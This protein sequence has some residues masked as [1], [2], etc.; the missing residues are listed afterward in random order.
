MNIKRDIARDSLG[1][2]N[3]L[4]GKLLVKE[5]NKEIE[6]KKFY[7]MHALYE[8]SM[9]TIK[10]KDE[11]IDRF[12]LV[13]MHCEI[14]VMTKERYAEKFEVKKLLGNLVI[15]FE[16]FIEYANSVL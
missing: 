8:D 5:A 14:N 11:E 6:N 3:R 15:I 1:L 13:R 4:K 10:A 7:H 12:R 16:I 9:A 2:F